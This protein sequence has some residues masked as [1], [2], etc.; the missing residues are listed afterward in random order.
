MKKLTLVFSSLL[1]L[2]FTAFNANAISVGVSV[3]QSDFDGTGEGHDGAKE[4]K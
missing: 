4:R 2:L 1:F 3:I